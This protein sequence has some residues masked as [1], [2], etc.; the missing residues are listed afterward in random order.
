M[1][2]LKLVL[3]AVVLL[4]MGMF[5]GCQEGYAKRSGEEYSKVRIYHQRADGLRIPSYSY[6]P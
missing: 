3:L 1:K 4:L 2:T 6:R 5:A